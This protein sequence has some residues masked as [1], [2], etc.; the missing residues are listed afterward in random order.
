[1]K[2]PTSVT[3]AIIVF[4]I[5]SVVAITPAIAVLSAPFAIRDKHV[6]I[7]GALIGTALLA[8]PHVL[9]LIGLIKRKKW[10]RYVSIVILACWILGGIVMILTSISETRWLAQVLPV[11]LVNAALTW[12]LVCL[13]F[14]RPAAEYFDGPQWRSSALALFFST[15]GRLNRARYFR[16]QLA[17]GISAWLITFGIG[18]IIEPSGG[19]SGPLLWSIVVGLGASIVNAFQVVK[20]LH[21]LDR[22]GSHYWQTLI[23][24]Y[25]IYFGFVLL[26]QKGTDGTNTYGS[27][28]L[29]QASRNL[30]LAYETGR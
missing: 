11:L 8:T 26:F 30:G 2:R 3:A 25:N 27:N 24:L 1:M 23:P 14:R 7:V 5:I 22:P 13:A 15:Q 6:A 16:R 10:G 21:D 4:A 18:L 19:D 28:P 17:I 29:T 12:L 20:R 9:A